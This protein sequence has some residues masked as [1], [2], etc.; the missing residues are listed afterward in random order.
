MLL[1]P[2]LVISSSSALSD[3]RVTPKKAADVEMNSTSVFSGDRV[4]A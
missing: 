1:G 2:T 3:L 4:S